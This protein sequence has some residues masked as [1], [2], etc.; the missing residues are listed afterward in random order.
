MQ[1]YDSWVHREYL[2]R[3]TFLVLVQITHERFEMVQ[4]TSFL[5]TLSCRNDRL[6]ARGGRVEYPISNKAQSQLGTSI[7]N[8]ASPNEHYLHLN[9]LTKA[10]ASPK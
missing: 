9:K 7:S 5:A 4:D 10:S 2:T 1:P 6:M 8:K 3:S